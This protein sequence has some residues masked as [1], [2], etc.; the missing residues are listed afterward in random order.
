MSDKQIHEGELR[1]ETAHGLLKAHRAA[2]IRRVQRAYLTI[3]LERG[4]VTADDVREIVPLPEG[5]SPKACGP[6]PG[7]LAKAGALRADGYTKSCR[8]KAHARPIAIWRLG[9]AS[10][11]KA[12]LASHPEIDADSE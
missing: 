11:A 2:F 8:P 4:V 1:K 7:E 10:K 12:W 5:V 6:A 9:D 3:A